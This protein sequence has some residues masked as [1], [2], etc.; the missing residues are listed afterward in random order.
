VARWQHLHPAERLAGPGALVRLLQQMR[1]LPA[2]GVV[3]E[4]DLLPLRLEAYDPKELEALCQQGEVVW[5]GSGGKDP[6]RARVRFLFRGEG[7]LFLAP[8]PEDLDLSPAASEVLAF[9]KSEGAC[10]YADLETGTEW[11][12]DDLTSALF[13]LVMAGLV[14]NDSLDALRGMLAWSAEADAPGRK[15]LSSLEAELAAWRKEQKPA[16]SAPAGARQPPSRAR[17]QAAKRAV[18]RRTAPRRAVGRRPE[19]AGSPRWPGRWSLV[20]RFGVWG[21]EVAYEERIARQARQLLQC[22]GIVTRQSLAGDDQSGWHWPALYA[23]FQLMEMR[24]EVRRGYFVQGLPGVQ[25]ALPEAVE[26]LREWTRA[27]APGSEGPVLSHAEGPVVL[28]A[29]DPA[30]LFGPAGVLG[31][32]QDPDPA[33]PD[34]S[35]LSDRDMPVPDHEL[36]GKDPARFTRIPANYVVLLRGRPVLLLET[37]GERASALPD[38]P[39][40]TLRRALKLAVDQIGG[41]VRRL[42]LSQWNGQPVLDS[43]AAPLLEEVGFRREAL[44]YIW[45]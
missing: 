32:A 43:P 22:Y 33:P 8:E 34:A 35:E 3:W 13:E 31:E 27:P 23:Q 44:V 41:S 42:T 38:L 12:G 30:N 17:V 18:A 4:R 15:P 6:R 39:P 7:N 16:T 9:L 36:V 25:F 24:G 29:C 10:F 21:R 1:G 5:V 40:D 19:S 45:E 28:N 20:H 26:R 14:T 2:P 37:G 11:A